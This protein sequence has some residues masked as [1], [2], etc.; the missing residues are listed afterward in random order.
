MPAIEMLD[1]IG[2]NDFKFVH[3]RHW[4]IERFHR[5]AKQLCNFETFQVRTSKAIMNHI[6]CALTTFVTLEFLRVN[7]TI[8]NWY[9]LQR[10]VLNS[11]LH[12]FLQLLPSP[13][14][15]ISSV[16]SA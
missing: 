9:Q 13:I 14:Q 8:E 1:T 2:V 12:N 10:G 7:Q 6:F 16:S 4:N 15:I 3:D 5:A 11:M